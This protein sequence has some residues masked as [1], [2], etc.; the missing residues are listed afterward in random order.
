M[1]VDPD[2]VSILTLAG[3]AAVAVAVVVANRYRCAPAWDVWF[4]YCLERIYLPFM[5][6]WRSNRRSPF[7]ETGGALIIANHRS[8]VDPLMIWMNH[9]LAW[10]SRRVRVIS[11]LTAKEYCDLPGVRFITRAMRSIPVERGGTDMGPAREALRRLQ[12]GDLIGVF[13]EGRINMGEGLLEATSGI[14]WLALRAQAPVFPVYIHGTPQKDDM[15]T[16]FYTPSRVRVTF[17]EPIDL[18]AYRNRPKSRPVL[19]EVTRLLMERLAITG[20]LDPAGVRVVERE[21]EGE[22]GQ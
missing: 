9:H 7:P 16:P 13:P 11:F 10:P 22:G 6:H 3:Y 21:R 1:Q 17:G 20:G 5:F 18:S 2:L 8:P 12:A 19:M 15:V 4:L 14:A